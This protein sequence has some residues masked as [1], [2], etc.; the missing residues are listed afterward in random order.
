MTE[1]KNT[2]TY[3][4]EVFEIDYPGRAFPWYRELDKPACADVRC[5]L[6]RRI[7][8]AAKTPPIELL[9]MLWQRA[10]PL[11]LNPSDE[12]FDPGAALEAS[13]I[14]PNDMVYLDWSAFTEIYEMRFA[15]FRE[16][17]Q[18]LFFPSADDLTVF[19]DTLTWVLWL[20]HYCELALS[21]LPEG[22]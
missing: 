7:G 16:H 5:R 3:K 13:G 21:R 20:L 4:I 2:I 11:N 22:P 19:D 9:K 6:R 8:C 1:H 17:V 15:D 10:T 12:A 14:I 18:S